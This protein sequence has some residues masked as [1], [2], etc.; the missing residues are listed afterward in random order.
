MSPSLQTLDYAADSMALSVPCI[1]DCGLL[2]PIQCVMGSEL[3]DTVLWVPCPGITSL[4]NIKAV[5]GTLVALYACG[6][7]RGSLWLSRLGVKLKP[8]LICMIKSCKYS[9]SCGRVG[10]VT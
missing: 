4:V 6:I 8:P 2:P 7:K 3:V 10:P 9:K 5:E 1:G